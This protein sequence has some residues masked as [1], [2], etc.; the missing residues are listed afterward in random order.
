MKR[1]GVILL[2][3]YQD[4]DKPWK[5]R[6]VKC[7]RIVWPSYANERR[8]QGGCK[9]CAD[10]GIDFVALAHLYVLYHVLLNAYKVGVGEEGATKRNDRISNLS[11]QGWVLI[12]K[13]QYESG[14]DAQT[15][16]FSIL[17]ELRNVQGIS[18][19]LSAQEMKRAG[20]YTE[21]IDADRIAITELAEVIE[22]NQEFISL[23]SV[24]FYNLRNWFGVL[25]QTRS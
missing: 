25:N 4:K 24:S 22:G 12:K 15:V 10:Y 16:G 1:A 21:T 9:Y 17:N 23:R 18:V 5:S 19:F 3:P 11:K 2:V 6:C 7:E 13:Y 20:G 14:L 8:G